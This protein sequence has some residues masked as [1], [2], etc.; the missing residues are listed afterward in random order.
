MYFLLFSISSLIICFVKQRQVSKLMFANLMSL[1]YFTCFHYSLCCSANFDI[2]SFRSHPSHK[3][4]QP[5]TS[6]ANTWPYY[7]VFRATTCHWGCI[8]LVDSKS[9]EFVVKVFGGII[10]PLATSKLF[11]S[12]TRCDVTHFLSVGCFRFNWCYVRFTNLRSYSSKS[13]FYDVFRQDKCPCLDFKR[14]FTCLCL[15]SF[16]T[17]KTLINCFASSTCLWIVQRSR[18]CWW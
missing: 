4:H 7:T 17:R 2:D 11:G 18:K 5:I 10:F 15:R 14:I 8:Y 3:Q 13:Q 12:I 1:L 9:P 16:D 6:M